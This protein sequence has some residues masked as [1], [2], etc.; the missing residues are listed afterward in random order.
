[1]PPAGWTCC[2]EK[3]CARLILQSRLTT[4]WSWAAQWS[5]CSAWWR[6]ASHLC[7]SELFLTTPPSKRLGNWASLPALGDQV[8]GLAPD[9]E[10]YTVIYEAIL[11][12]C[13]VMASLCALAV[14]SL[15]E[16]TPSAQLPVLSTTQHPGPCCALQAA[17]PQLA[18]T[19]LLL[20]AP[21]AR[22]AAL[23]QQCTS[24]ACHMLVVK[25]LLGA[26]IKVSGLAHGTPV[27]NLFGDALCS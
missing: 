27:E 19:P 24:G 25:T 17:A 26:T 13:I 12:M 7:R 9:T 4:L 1:M 2:S 22:Q 8:V 23:S 10:Y 15:T 21:L 16:R 20:I 18:S 3:L 11:P 6:R 14:A 5:S